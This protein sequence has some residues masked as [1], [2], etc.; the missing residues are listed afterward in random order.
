MDKNTPSSK[1]LSSLGWLEQRLPVKAFFKRHF[2]DYTMPAAIS[3]LWALGDVLC[4]LFLLMVLSGV[5]LALFYVPTAEG[6]FS[7]I[8]EIE[9][10]IPG[11]WLIRAIHVS[12]ASIFMVFLYGHLLRGLYYLS[13]RA[14]RELAWWSG[15]LLLGMF[16]GVAFAGYVLPW[17]QISYWAADVVGQAMGAIPLVGHSLVVWIQG[18]ER[19]T[20]V[21]L[22]RL[23]VLHFV[24][25]FVAVGVI[26]AH[27]I[28]V[29]CVYGFLFHR[30]KERKKEGGSPSSAVPPEGGEQAR[31]KVANSGAVKKVLLPFAPYFLMRDALVMIAAFLAM[32]VLGCF[33]SSW[34]VEADNWRPANP[35]KTP[36]QVETVWYFQPFYGML[37]AV[38]SKMWGVILA[39]GSIGLLFFL[40][41]L[42]CGKKHLLKEGW[43]YRVGLTLTVIAFIVLGLAGKAH[44]A[45]AWLWTA[46]LALVWYYVFFLLAVPLLSGFFSSG[47]FFS[48]GKKKIGEE[49]NPGITGKG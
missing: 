3:W 20:E 24:L 27:I 47:N 38:P 28:M 39:G 13:Y 4:I 26:F 41:W 42:D 30:K 44:M 36:A 19:P 40:P 25:G 18:A 34:L 49:E 35:F 2:Q 16:M 6:A 31:I 17:G 14:P 33:F 15:L 9:R 10:H 46:R 5:F 45:G 12:G 7:S 43:L 21:Y 8:Q 1:D 11:G 23:F 29:R 48:S 37:Q 22:H 32:V